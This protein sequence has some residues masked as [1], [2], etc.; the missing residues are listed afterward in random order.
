[1]NAGER[2]EVAFDPV[3][4]PQLHVTS[5]ALWW[6]YQFGTPNL[7][8]LSVAAATGGATSDTRSINFGI[9]QFTDYRATVNGTSFVGY[10]INGQNILFRGGGYVWDML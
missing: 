1:L 5:P 10:R 7:Y 3:T 8:Q 4:Y 9:R 2:R 6:P